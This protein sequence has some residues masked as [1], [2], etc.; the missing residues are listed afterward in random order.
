MML[1]MGEAYGTQSIVAQKGR[2]YQWK[3]SASMGNGIYYISDNITDKVVFRTNTDTKVGSGVKAC[4]GDGSL[5]EKAY[6]QVDSVAPNIYAIHVPAS[7]NNYVANDYLGIDENHQSDVAIPTHGIYWDINGINLNSQWTFVTEDDY[8]TAQA[9]DDIVAKLKK[10]LKAAK[11]K[12]IDVI[13]EQAIYDNPQSTLDELKEALVS[14]RAKLHFITFQD[15][16][17][18]TL[19]LNNWDTDGDGELTFE[20]AQAVTDIG[21]TFRGADISYFEEFRYFTSLTS[22]PDNAFRNGMAG[23]LLTAC[24]N[25]KQLLFRIFPYRHDGLHLKISFGNGSGLIH[26]HCTNLT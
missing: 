24:T 4:F 23:T 22:I 17:V 18:M 2:L 3:H 11:A 16:K 14:V 8:K 12:E 25:T 5:S 1:S 26:D 19:C 13:D 9:I 7:D 20:E 10:N 21:E 15:N 6:W